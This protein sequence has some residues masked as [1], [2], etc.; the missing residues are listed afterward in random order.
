[1]PSPDDTPMSR[2][3]RV[4][5]VA[6]MHRAGT[7]VIA[8]GLQV[9]RLDLGDALM[10]ADVRQ[11]ARGFFED[12]DVVKLD[13]ALLDGAG[14][15]WK[16]AALLDAVD[17][18][19][20]THAASHAAARRMLERKIAPTGRFAFKDPRIARLLPFWQRVFADL[21]VDDAYVIAVRHPQAVID[22]LTA[23]DGLDPRR[24]A[25]L[26]LTHFLC[27]M[28]YTNGRTR[29][30]VDYDRLLEAP[31]RELA[32]MARALRVP[33]IAEE[34]DLAAYASEFLSRELRHAAYAAEDLS[35]AAFTAEIVAAHDLAQRLARGESDPEAE[36]TIAAIDA[37]FE[38]L[39][40]LSPLLAYAGTVERMADEVPRLEAELAWARDSLGTSIRYSEDLQATIAR[41]DGELREG[42]AYNID[43]LANLKRI[44]GE[45]REAYA[46][47]ERLRANPAGRLLLYHAKRSR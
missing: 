15:D 27:A 44:E 38:A 8:R 24:S 31:V 5:V 30:V 4:V 35:S 40:A 18:S 11:N 13:D 42:Q 21:T 17:W 36:A 10:S 22:S 45:L 26:W 33:E 46:L 32:R 3:Q 34:R 29:V 7:S 28:H 39:R 2:R 16:S 6:G 20:A 47:L 25:L 23:R 37:Q 1:M 41:K 12:V 43:L 19:D 9:L 14:A